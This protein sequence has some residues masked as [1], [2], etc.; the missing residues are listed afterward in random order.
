MKPM[1]DVNVILREKL[2]AAGII[3]SRLESDEYSPVHLTYSGKRLPSML[4]RHQYELICTLFNN[5]KDRTFDGGGVWGNKIHSMMCV[6]ADPDLFIHRGA[7]SMDI[8]HGLVLTS[9]LCAEDR[10]AIRAFCNR[11]P[12]I[13]PR[14]W[15]IAFTGL[16]NK[17]WNMVYDMPRSPYDQMRVIDAY[18]LL[19][20]DEFMGEPM[21]INGPSIVDVTDQV[22]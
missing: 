8:K 9:F 16:H 19:F 11:I 14:T 15:L 4:D 18:K 1:N 21:K 10:G 22:L 20:T 6:A 7:E 5:H 17:L 12:E 2:F 3:S 13:I